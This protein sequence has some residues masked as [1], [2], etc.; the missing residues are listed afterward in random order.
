M[1][2]KNLNT[3]S[4]TEAR[5]ENST[6]SSNDLE[7][8]TAYIIHDIKNNITIL[9]YLEFFNKNITNKTIAKDSEEFIKILAITKQHRSS[10]QY[11][12]QLKENFQQIRKKFFEIKEIL[13]NEADSREEKELIIQ[14]Q[15]RIE[16]TDELIDRYIK[17]KLQ[18]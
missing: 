7:K 6:K 11:L 2:K 9:R 1:F 14:I 4:A 16:E 12:K 15:K 8:K 3:S 13:I 17:L 10:E 5:K 18:S